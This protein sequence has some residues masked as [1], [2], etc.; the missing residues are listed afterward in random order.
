MVSPKCLEMDGLWKG[1]IGSV[2]QVVGLEFDWNGNLEV[3]ASTGGFES[4]TVRR[5]QFKFISLH[6]FQLSPIP[7]GINRYYSRECAIESRLDTKHE[8]RNTRT[9][10]Y[11][12]HGIA[13][14]RLWVN[15]RSKWQN[16]GQLRTTQEYSSYGEDRRANPESWCLKSR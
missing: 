7:Q 14:T 4:N 11:G 13:Q 9:S 16:V 1:E 12:V 8:T 5:I 15:G 2:A 6:R 10:S 3:N